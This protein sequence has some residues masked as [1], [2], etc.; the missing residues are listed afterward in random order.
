[1]CFKFNLQKILYIEKIDGVNDEC[2]MVI[3]IHGA[4]CI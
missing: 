4:L 2:G 1:M 3:G